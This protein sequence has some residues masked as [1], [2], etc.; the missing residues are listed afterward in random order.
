MNSW[1][2]CSI[3]SACHILDNCRIPVSETERKKRKGNIPYYGANGIQ[4]YIDDYIFNEKLVLLAEDGGNF[5]DFSTRPIAYRIKG[6]SWVNNHAHVLKAR[7]SFDIDFIFYSLQHRNILKHITGGTRG[8]LNQSELK[9]IEFYCPVDIK[10]QKAISTILDTIDEAI[11]A[12]EAQLATQEKIKQGLL[13]D[14]L[15]RGI[16][17]TGQIR[18]HWEDRPDLYKKTDLGVIPKDWDIQNLDSLSSLI[19]SESRN[20][21]EFYS[22]VGAI[23]IRI[24]NLTRENINLRFDSIVYVD[25]SSNKEGQRTKLSP[26]DILVSITA[27]LGIVAVIPDDI[28]EAYINQYIALVRLNSLKVNSRFVGYFLASETVQNYITKLNDVGAKAG[29]NL[30]T[31][32]GLL[33]VIPDIQEQNLIV[34]NLDKAVNQALD[35][36]LEIRKLQQIKTGLMQDLLTGQRRVTPELIRQV[37]T[38][39]GIT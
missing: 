36:K 33:T 30:S 38:L 29:L 16:D 3:D 37:E 12:A 13:Q 7:N 19:T 10:E 5:E 2:N 8:K 6:F 35:S 39:T 32:R 28:G 9:L 17:E 18:P 27:D 23:F 14:L 31:I 21:A 25:L 26:G 4:G 1:I 34:D 24:G 22:N 11:A 15:T 20:W